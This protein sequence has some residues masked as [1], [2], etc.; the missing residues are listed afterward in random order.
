MFAQ[1]LL[2]PLGTYCSQI[3]C[4]IQRN[5]TNNR[6]SYVKKIKKRHTAR[7]SNLQLKVEARNLAR[8]KAKH[9]NAL[10]KSFIFSNVNTESI[11]KITDQMEY[12][13]YQ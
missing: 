12:E 5:S 3:I 7:R 13:M 2:L 8:Q 10:Q 4:T 9:T 6:N 11:A 1:N